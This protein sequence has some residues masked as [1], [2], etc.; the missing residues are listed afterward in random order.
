M[1]TWSGPTAPVE[2]RMEDCSP[3]GDYVSFKDNPS[4]T[5]N[6]PATWTPSPAGEQAQ[7]EGKRSQLAG[8]CDL[9][10]CVTHV[11]SGVV[12]KLLLTLHCCLALLTPGLFR[13][14]EVLQ[15]DYHSTEVKRK[16][17][18]SATSGERHVEVYVCATAFI[19]GQC[20]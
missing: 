15:P 16:K 8:C 10:G 13:G 4:K 6:P 19:L 18:S 17:I 2:A 9:S 5:A 20:N 12:C 3:G 1:S 7:G 11:W 14:D